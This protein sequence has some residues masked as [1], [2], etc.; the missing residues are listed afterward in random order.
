MDVTSVTETD[1]VA[2]VQDIVT[3]V[4][5][6]PVDMQRIVYPGSLRSLQPNDVLSQYGITKDATLC[7]FPRARGGMDTG[8]EIVATPTKNVPA[9]HHTVPPPH[10]H[11]PYTATEEKG[12]EQTTLEKVRRQI[13]M[14]HT[15]AHYWETR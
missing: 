15:S 6:I 14:G 11:G 8:D 2:T 3:A 13:M 4:W 10:R 5:G 9:P 7:V 1:T 12:V